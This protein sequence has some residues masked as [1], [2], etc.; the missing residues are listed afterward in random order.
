MGQK[1]KDTLTNKTMN[2]TYLKSLFQLSSVLSGK[3]KKIKKSAPG[4]TSEAGE[5][6]KHK[7][8]VST[9]E[10]RKTCRRNGTGENVYLVYNALCGST[11]STH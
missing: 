10:S 8:Q 6:N 5:E 1:M 4:I 7:I 9:K 3:K 11:M 2:T